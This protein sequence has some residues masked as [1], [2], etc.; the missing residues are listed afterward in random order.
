MKTFKWTVPEPKLSYVEKREGKENA[1][2]IIEGL[3]YEPAN[4]WE[5]RVLEKINESESCASVAPPLLFTLFSTFVIGAREGEEPYLWILWVI[6]LLLVVE[7]FQFRATKKIIL[8]LNET[9]LKS[10]PDDADNP[11]NPPRNSKNQ[12][13]D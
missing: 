10:E 11:C 4:W 8:K 6:T 5:R 1:E 13:D 3:K 2:E 12:P 7:K 9:N